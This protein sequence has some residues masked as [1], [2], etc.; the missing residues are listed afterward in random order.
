[1]YIPLAHKVLNILGHHLYHSGPSFEREQCSNGQTIPPKQSWKERE[2]KIIYNECEKW[3]NLILGSKGEGDT[4][5][6]SFGLQTLL[7]AFVGQELL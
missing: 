2:R 1:M 4:K 3:F 5:L 6:T 7:E